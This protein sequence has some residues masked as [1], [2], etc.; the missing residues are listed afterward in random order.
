MK[1][2]TLGT[3]GISVS[4]IGFGAWG[5]GGTTPG[6]TS[7]GVAD[8]DT[9][10]RALSRAR[11]MGINFFDTSP[12][13]GYGHSEA[14]IGRAFAGARD[15]VV[16][17]T[18]GGLVEYGRPADFRADVLRRELEA[19]L[20]RLGTDHVDLYQLHNPSPDAMADGALAEL[21]AALR[22]E[23]K[24]RAFGVSVRGPADGILAIERLRPD[25]IQVNFNMMDQR[26]LDDGLLSAAARASV[27]L[28]ARTP[29]C[30]GFLSGTV[31]ETSR[32]SA[33]DHRSRWPWAQLRRWAETGRRMLGCRRGGAEQTATQ[34]ALRYCLSFSEF[35]TVIPGMMTPGEVEENAAASA[36]GPLSADEIAQIGRCYREADLFQ[37]APPDPG[38]VDASP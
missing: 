25:A 8:D 24:I 5:I 12:V 13:Y 29:L 16:I 27:A 31:D 1:F 20:A 10:I 34:F 28:I 3:T 36:L 21:A 37:D 33:D 11:E 22:C 32:F 18:K 19:S 14:L 15:G 7:Y 17:A 9:S 4:E 30:F 26:V 38:K 6:A 2:R 35:A 23:G